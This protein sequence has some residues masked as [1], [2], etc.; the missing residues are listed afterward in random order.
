V[1]VV[2]AGSERT[3]RWKVCGSGTLLCE[4]LMRFCRIPAAFLRK[5][6]GFQRLPG[7]DAA[8]W[9]AVRREADGRIRDVP[10][11]LI[12]GSDKSIKAVQTAGENLR[13]LP[14][15]DRVRLRVT[16][17][18]KIPAIADS[19]IVTNPPAGVRI[20]VKEGTDVFTK[21]FGDFLKQR[22][23]G[24]TACIYFTDRALVKHIGLRTAWKKPLRNGPLDGRL[25]RIDL[26]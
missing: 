21:S 13:R 19:L 11:G 2:P 20:G 4:A 18:E 1:S 23:K 17:F 14:H 24:S 25:V 26:Y 6:F 5:R 3:A 15:G 7:F 9:Q 16:A 22:C 12:S 10:D 8:V